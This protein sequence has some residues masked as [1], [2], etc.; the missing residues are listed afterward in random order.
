MTPHQKRIEL[1]LTLDQIVSNLMKQNDISATEMEDALN[2]TILV[3][4]ERVMKEFLISMAQEK[5]QQEKEQQQQQEGNQEQEENQEFVEPP[6][7]DM[8][9]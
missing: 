1:Q 5:E 6:Q 3:N 2:Y 9:E 7:T 8:E 4:K